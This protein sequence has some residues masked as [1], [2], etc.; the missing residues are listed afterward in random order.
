MLSAIILVCMQAGLHDVRDCTIDNASQIVKL[1][2][3]F[4]TED[5]CVTRGAVLGRIKLLREMKPGDKL[6]VVC[7]H[8]PSDNTLN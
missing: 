7:K 8:L 2:Q 5:E 6:K 3:S 1:E 4:F